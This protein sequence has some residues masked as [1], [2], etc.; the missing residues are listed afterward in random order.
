[1]LVFMLRWLEKFPQFKT[2]D[3]FLAGESYA[4]HYIPQLADVILEY[5]AR[6]SNRFKFNLK[7]IAV[8]NK[9]KNTKSPSQFSVLL[10]LFFDWFLC[11]WSDRES[12]FEAWPGYSSNVWVLLVPWDDLWWTWPHY[13]EP[14]RLWRLH[15]HRFTQHKQTLWS[16]SER[17]WNHHHS[18]CQLL[19][20]SPR[21]LLP[22]PCRARAQAQENGK[23]KTSLPFLLFGC[24]YIYIFILY[25]YF[26]KNKT[27]N[28][29]IWTKLFSTKIYTLSV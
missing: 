29:R 24:V 27:T 19:R 26:F 10:A 13:H 8:S 25:H 7:G 6:R 23:K 9:N 18:I 17:S 1:M 3:L 5:N 14:M 28:F 20:R 4:G 2:R 16:R 15:I 22:V 21:Y 11:F 12:A